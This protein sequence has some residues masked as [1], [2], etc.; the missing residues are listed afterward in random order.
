VIGQSGSKGSGSGSGF[1]GAAGGKGAGAGFSR[2][3]AGG[4]AGSACRTQNIIDIIH[5]RGGKKEARFLRASQRAHH[6]NIPPLAK[7]RTKILLP[8]GVMKGS[9]IQRLVGSELC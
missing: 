8:K 4:A 3:L 6:L 1:G 2:G 9:S 7:T 5:A